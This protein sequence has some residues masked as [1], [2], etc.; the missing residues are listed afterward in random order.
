MPREQIDP[1]WAARLLA[2]EQP[3]PC[4]YFV[5]WEGGPI[6]IGRAANVQH[7]L[8]QMQVHCPYDLRL[9]ATRKGG[10]DLEAFYHSV[11][12]RD[13]IRG[14]WFERSWHLEQE[15]GKLSGEVR[16]WPMIFPP[17]SRVNPRKRSLNPTGPAP[18]APL[19][20]AAAAK[21][22]LPTT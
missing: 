22:R 16:G 11:F 19:C 20:P 10:A 5:G 17:R 14:E 7:R 1:Q 21:T 12:A 13:R 4:V 6:K 15:I 8:H 18:T 3:E 2:T 9:L